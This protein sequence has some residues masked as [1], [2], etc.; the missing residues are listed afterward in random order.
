MVCHEVAIN[1]SAVFRKLATSRN[2]KH[3]ASE[4]NSRQINTEQETTG[5]SGASLSM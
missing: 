2:S 4:L 5:D 1:M 3:Q